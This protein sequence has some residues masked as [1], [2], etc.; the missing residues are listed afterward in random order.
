M[1]DVCG[2]VEYRVDIHLL[3]RFKGGV[4]GYVA[5]EYLNPVVDRVVKVAAEVVV[6]NVLEA[7]LGGVKMTAADHTVRLAGLAVQEFSEQMSAHIADSAGNQ[8]VSELARLA[9]LE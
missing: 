3:K 4:V 2:A 8:H 9:G 5:A 1:L 6:H 7:F